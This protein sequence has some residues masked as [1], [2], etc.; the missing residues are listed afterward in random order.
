[1]EIVKTESYAYD[2]LLF[3]SLDKVREYRLQKYAGSFEKRAPGY[4]YNTFKEELSKDPDK[5]I[6]DI[7]EILYECS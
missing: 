4:S 2:H 3:S 7:K 1:M 5:V 6:A